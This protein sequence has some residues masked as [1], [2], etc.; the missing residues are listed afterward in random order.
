[1]SFGELYDLGKLFIV[2]QVICS[3]V[4]MSEIVHLLARCNIPEE[5]NPYVPSKLQLKV[6][7]YSNIIP[8]YLFK[9]GY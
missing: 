8:F 6:L 2:L 1:M 7:I 4:K 5:M 3:T 9:V